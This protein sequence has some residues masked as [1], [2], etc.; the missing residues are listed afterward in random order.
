MSFRFFVSV[1]RV[2]P[3]G[4]RYAVWWRQVVSFCRFLFFKAIVALPH[5]WFLVVEMFLKER[6]AGF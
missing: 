4:I 6:P 5:R 1:L 3:A 2:S